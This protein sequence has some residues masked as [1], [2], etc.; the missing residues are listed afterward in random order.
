VELLDVEPN[1]ATWRLRAGTREPDAKTGAEPRYDLSG[2]EAKRVLFSIGMGVSTEKRPAGLATDGKAVLAVGALSRPG[3]PSGA[4]VVQ[5]DGALSIARSD[6][7]TAI[8]AHVD[9]AEVPLIVDRGAVIYAP[10]GSVEERAALGVTAG[11]RLLLAR[12]TFPSD[13]PLGEALRAAGCVRAVALARGPH[14]EVPLRRSGTS[15]PPR[16]RD[17]ATT[18]FAIAAPMKPRA[19][20][21]EPDGVARAG[22]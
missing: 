18:L 22:R 12:G 1:R 17:E 14:A 3:A 21:F 5:G 7:V 9:V 4:I 10:A 13:G 11:G 6:E 16:A 19:F 20:R 2:D 15:T 8:G